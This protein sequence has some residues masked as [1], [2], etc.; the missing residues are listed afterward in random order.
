MVLRAA[1]NRGDKTEQD[2]A[3]VEIIL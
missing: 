3:K 2:L 1:G